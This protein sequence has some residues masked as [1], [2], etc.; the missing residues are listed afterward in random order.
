MLSFIWV[1]EFVLDIVVKIMMH[2]REQSLAMGEEIY[3]SPVD[4][5]L[6]FGESLKSLSILQLLR[7]YFDTHAHGS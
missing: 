7:Q 2:A 3:K 1:I 4:T 6:G 5:F